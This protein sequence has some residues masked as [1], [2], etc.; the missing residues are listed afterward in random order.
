MWVYSASYYNFIISWT[1]I[2]IL[3]IHITTNWPFHPFTLNFTPF[4]LKS[5]G[6]WKCRIFTIWWRTLSI[7]NH[8]MDNTNPW[9][10][11]CEG[12]SL[13][14][15]GIAMILLPQYFPGWMKIYVWV[16]FS[17]ENT[18]NAGLEGNSLVKSTR[19]LIDIFFQGG[20]FRPNR[21]VFNLMIPYRLDTLQLTQE[22]VKSSVAQCST[23]WFKN[24]FLEWMEYVL[25]MEL[26][27]I[28]F[29]KYGISSV[30]YGTQMAVKYEIWVKSLQLQH[31]LMKCN[32]V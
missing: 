26:S 21:P 9:S 3:I 8:W 29:V 2:D 20:I 13:S 28:S 30:K 32:Y 19:Y 11:C 4:T 5:T 16:H 10:R 7:K 25:S 17:K 12:N 6:A 18:V 22:K 14:N 1:Y 24:N 27:H 31:T 23:G 15:E